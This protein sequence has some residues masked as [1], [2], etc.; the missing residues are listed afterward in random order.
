MENLTGGTPPVRY[1][2]CVVPCK[3][4]FVS[5]EKIEANSYIIFPYKAVNGRP[6][7]YSLAEMTEDF[8]HALAYLNRFKD[9]LDERNMPGRTTEN[10]FAF[11][12]SQSLKRFLAGEHLVWPVLS[13]SSNYV[14][15]NDMVVFT[16]GGNGPFYGIEKKATSQESIFYIQAILNHWLMELLVKSR[17]STFRGDYYSHGKQFIA[18]LPI[19]KIDFENPAEVAKHQQI[20]EMVQNIM[21][22]KEQLAFAP[23][24]ARRTV[25][26]HSITAINAELNSAIDE[27]YQ[28]ES[29]EVE[30]QV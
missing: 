24:A 3:L 14:Y 22:L 12:R 16:G 10:W 23:N 30:E 29:Q 19:F 27:L 13:T 5:Y 9:K 28:V 6:V 17:A 2:P 21:Q 26:E 4:Y 11:G 8:P 1:L 7:L 18:T 15:D 20:V 25:L